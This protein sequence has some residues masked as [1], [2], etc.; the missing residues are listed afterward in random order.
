MNTLQKIN[1]ALFSVY[2]LMQINQMLK[3]KPANLQL[4]NSPQDLQNLNE[5]AAKYGEKWLK[6][7]QDVRKKL[8]QIR[9]REVSVMEALQWMKERIELDPLLSNGDIPSI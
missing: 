4:S 3:G 8:V 7:F 9:G 5:L 6:V 1:T 2:I